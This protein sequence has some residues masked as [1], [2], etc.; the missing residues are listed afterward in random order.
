M[1][2]SKNKLFILAII[3]VSMV[4]LAVAQSAFSQTP[5]AQASP[6]MLLAQDF[7]RNAPPG[8]N[9][10]LPT[11]T[12]PPGGSPVSPRAG[13]KPLNANLGQLKGIIILGSYEDF[14][15]EGVGGIQGL[16]IK[17]PTFL[18]DHKDMVS[19]GV[20]DFLGKPLGRNALDRLQVVLIRLC[21]QLDR[22]MVDVYY[23]EQEI[24]DGVVQIIIY[25]GKVGHVNVVC[26]TTT[27]RWFND[28]Y[29]KR[30]GN[31]N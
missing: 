4:S 18:K 6:P 24:L 23:P 9:V 5:A 29:L 16:D 7:Q 30:G 2:S 31:V 19:F 8:S 22:P 10:P 17:G 28:A 13:E 26:L 12:A 3:A 11:N 15:E 1:D 27:N 21:R 25:E 20:K 14:K